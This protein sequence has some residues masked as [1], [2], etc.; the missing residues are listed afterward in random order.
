MVFTILIKDRQR[1]SF[2]LFYFFSYDIRMHDV[3]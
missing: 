2:Y 3:A 1:E